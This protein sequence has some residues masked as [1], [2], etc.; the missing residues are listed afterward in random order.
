[1]DNKVGKIASIKSEKIVLKQPEPC[2]WRVFPDFI[3]S[4]H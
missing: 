3:D 1:M 4:L 2:V